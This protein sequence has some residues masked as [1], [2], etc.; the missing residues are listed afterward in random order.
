MAAV[1][2]EEALQNKDTSGAPLN[3]GRLEVIH[4]KHFK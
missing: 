4:K 2:L 1:S 3:Y